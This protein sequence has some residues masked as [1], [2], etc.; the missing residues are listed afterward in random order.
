[1][2][3][4]GERHGLYASGGVVG[5]S[6]RTPRYKPSRRC[7]GSTP[8][9]PVYTAGSDGRFA[10]A[11]LFLNT[12]PASTVID[13]RY[14]SRSMEQNPPPPP[15][16]SPEELKTKTTEFMKQNFGDHVSAAAFPAPEPAA[17]EREE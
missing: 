9:W 12:Q 11:A 5:R 6:G 3:R 8:A 4:L 15:F 1:M 16:P 13:R 10:D 2:E 17:G 14:R 7:D